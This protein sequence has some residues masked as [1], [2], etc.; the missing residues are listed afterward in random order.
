MKFNVLHSLT[1]VDQLTLLRIPLL[2]LLLVLQEALLVFLPLLLLL[3]LCS[4]L[5]KCC[6]LLLLM[7]VRRRLYIKKGEK[8]YTQKLDMLHI[9]IFCWT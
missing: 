6:Q 5:L 3:P 9:M 2:Q 4:L 1:H 7:S 8:I